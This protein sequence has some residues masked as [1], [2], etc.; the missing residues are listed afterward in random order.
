MIYL[1]F[2]E[3]YKLLYLYKII[4][5]LFQIKFVM[6]LPITNFNYIFES[7]LSHICHFYLDLD[8]LFSDNK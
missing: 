7:I 3:F 2:Q 8:K 1:N 6:K 4:G 5:L